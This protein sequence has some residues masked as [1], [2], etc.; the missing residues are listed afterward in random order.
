MELAT[1]VSGGTVLLQVLVTG[2]DGD[3]ATAGYTLTVERIVRPGD[4][5]PDVSSELVVVEDASDVSGEVLIGDVPQGGD[6]SGHDAGRHEVTSDLATDS[7]GLND[8]AA[9]SN[10]EDTLVWPP[11][12][13]SG[14]SASADGFRG[15][16]PTLVVLVALI[17][18]LVFSRRNRRFVPPRD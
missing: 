4:E 18:G 6:E 10:G 14:C 15:L 3:C 7:T 17:L 16:I 13:S 1:E 8:L 9:D 5:S 11:P 2:C 12:G